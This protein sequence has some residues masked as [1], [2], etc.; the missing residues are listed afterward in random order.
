MIS[1]INQKIAWA[2]LSSRIKQGLVAVLSVTFGISMYIF[3]NSFMTG[4]NDAQTDLA[5]SALAHVRIFN[6]GPEDRSNLLVSQYPE[7]Y[8]FH[9]HNARNIQYTEGI[10]NAE[11]ILQ[12]VAEVEGVASVA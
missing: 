8:V 7:D 1:P 9:I 10:R 2:H 12:Q 6:D 4:V 3:M 11:A 5:F